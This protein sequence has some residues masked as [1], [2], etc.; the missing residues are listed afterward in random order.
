MESAVITSVVKA[1]KTVSVTSTLE[2][3]SKV[4]MFCN[5]QSAT[6]LSLLTD[7]KASFIAFENLSKW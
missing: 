5:Q 6:T 1:V 4:I 7:E 3:V 2:H